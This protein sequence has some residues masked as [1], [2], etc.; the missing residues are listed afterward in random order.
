MAERSDRARAFEALHVKGDPLVLFN[1]WD[2]GSARAVADAGARAIATGSWSVASAQGYPDG[3]AIPLDLLEGIA[4]RITSAVDLPVTVDLEGGYA[5]TPDATAANVERIA[6]A[7]A[8]GINL[9]DGVIGAAAPSLHGVAEQCARIAAVCRMAEARGLP[10]F[11]NARTDLFLQSAAA[12]HAALVEEALVRADAY[13]AAGASGL[14][15]PGLA[16]AGAIG[17]ICAASRLPVNVMMRDG[18][19][20]PS[21]LAALGVA[22]ISHGPGP[23]RAAMAWLSGQARIA[24]ASPS[25]D[26]SGAAPAR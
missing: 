12:S 10:L 24:L 17:R 21:R 11:V 3:E 4:R 23:C 26:V 9:E 1:I 8:V 13:A 18:V 15:V 19:P 20:P 2:A 14:F 7:G 16:D 22:R 6:A 25:G 5:I